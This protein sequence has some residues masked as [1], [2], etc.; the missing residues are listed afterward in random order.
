ME[1]LGIDCIN[2]CLIH[3]LDGASWDTLE[4]LGVICF[5]DRA[6]ANGR[7]VN[8]GFSFHGMANDFK[9]I[10]DAYPWVFCQIQYTFPDQ[11]KQAGT[12]GL[13]YVVKLPP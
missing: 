2:Y 5:L 1:K 10:V 13:K 6:E 4:G 3:A 11:D 9:R 7:I 8:A 12:E